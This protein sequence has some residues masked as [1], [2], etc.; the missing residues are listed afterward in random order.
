MKKLAV[1]ILLSLALSGCATH[2]QKIQINPN[3][4]AV[5]NGTNRQNYIS[6][7][8]PDIDPAIDPVLTVGEWYGT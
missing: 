7:P 8:A 1:I 6:Q 3:T 2:S 4:G 5:V